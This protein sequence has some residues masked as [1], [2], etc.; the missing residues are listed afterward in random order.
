[1]SDFSLID[2]AGSELKALTREGQGRYDRLCRD[3]YVMLGGSSIDV[4][5]E[6]ED[7][8]V[9]FRKT[10]DVYRSISRGSVYE[11]YGLMTLFPGV[12]QYILNDRVDNVM[13]IWRN[14]GFS[15][16]GTGAAAF[17]PISAAFMQGILRGGGSGF[18]GAPG[19]AGDLVTYFLSMQ[20]LNLLEKIFAR[21]INFTYR[22]ETRMLQI[23]TYP[24]ALEIVAIHCSVLKTYDELLQNHFSTRFLHDYMLATCKIIL[25]EK[26]TVF[27]T[28]PG[29]QGGV[30]TKGA[31][32][33]QKGAEEQV[34]AMDRLYENDDS[35]FIAFPT[36]G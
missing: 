29:A 25:G 6:D 21:D 32:L 22:P 33:K 36:R 28:L 13:K 27:G 19:A 26:L 8:E 30:Q 16:T 31:E 23:M 35:G 24:Q 17:D 12:Q 5:L 10:V 3:V 20:Q 2:Q 11:C 14:R 1:M 4:E 7:Y 34:T 15:S 9:A 18:G